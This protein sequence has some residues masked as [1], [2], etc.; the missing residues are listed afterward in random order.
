MATTTTTEPVLFCSVRRCMVFFQSN[1]AF[2]SVFQGL[3]TGRMMVGLYCIRDCDDAERV[4][5]ETI[6]ADPFLSDTC[7]MKASEWLGKPYL[8][9][10]P[11]A[12]R[13]LPTALT[14]ILAAQPNFG[15]NL[16]RYNGP[17]CVWD[18]DTEKD[19]GPLTAVSAER[20]TIRTI[21]KRMA[22]EDARSYH[23]GV[24]SN[25]SWRLLIKANFLTPEGRAFSDRLRK[26]LSVWFSESDKRQAIEDADDVEDNEHVTKPMNLSVD[27]R[28]KLL[29]SCEAHMGGKGGLGFLEEVLQLPGTVAD[30]EVPKKRVRTEE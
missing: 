16:C 23:V 15:L 18:A 22:E 11:Q 26:D 3:E 30:G 7:E 20:S 24:L 19:F 27:T 28:R 17:S 12:F 6:D 21:E 9:M 13:H 2:L 8:E 5:Q 29:A 1:H 14:A 10:K 25:S 4:M